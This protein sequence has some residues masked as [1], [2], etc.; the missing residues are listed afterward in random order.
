VHHD[1]ILAGFRLSREQVEKMILDARVKA[2][3]IEEA[4]LEE[5]EE[6]E[7]DASPEE[8]ASAGEA[9]ASG[10]GA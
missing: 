3:W 9:P 7:E 6:I 1:G 4:A 2:G 8:E 10:V 5:A